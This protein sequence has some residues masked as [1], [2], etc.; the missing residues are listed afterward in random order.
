LSVKLSRVCRDVVHERVQ[1]EY[2]ESTAFVLKLDNAKLKGE[3]DVMQ[4]KLQEA[5]EH[6]ERI[7]RDLEKMKQYATTMFDT[8]H[9]YHDGFVKDLKK[10]S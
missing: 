8:L 7:E 2:G 6:I 3:I 1:N 10:V 5:N 4:A 9:A